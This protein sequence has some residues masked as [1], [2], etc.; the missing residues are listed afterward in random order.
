MDQLHLR[1]FQHQHFIT[2]QIH[3]VEKWFELIEFT[4]NVLLNYKSFSVAAHLLQDKK[5][6]Q[7]Q[8]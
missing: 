1:K 7:R 4:A 3:N 6:Q 5:Y 8:L 2:Q